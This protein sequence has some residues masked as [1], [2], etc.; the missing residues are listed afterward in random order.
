MRLG[1]LGQRVFGRGQL[2]CQHLLLGIDVLP[3]HLERRLDL[4]ERRRKAV[5]FEH[6][7]EDSLLGRTKFFIG[8]SDLGLNGLIL[9]VGLHHRKLPLELGEPP[10]KDGSV[11]LELAPA[12]LTVIQYRGGGVDLTDG[13][14][15]EVVGGL[16]TLGVGIDGAAGLGDRRRQAL[17][18]DESLQIW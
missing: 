13:F 4:L 16:E 18:L 17:Q 14:I 10:L 2:G 12:S 8:R 7:L 3:S 15:Q 6:A 11:L 9:A 1:G 5:G